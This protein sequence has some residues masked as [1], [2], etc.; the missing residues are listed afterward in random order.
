MAAKRRHCLK[1]P[2]GAGGG[3]ADD[4][5]FRGFRRFNLWNQRNLRQSA[6]GVDISG[7]G[8][9]IAGR[10]GCNMT[11]LEKLEELVYVGFE[12][13]DTMPSSQR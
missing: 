2:G 8:V 9:Y 3:I 11:T 6:V 13:T 5:R 7:W 4:H 1:Q 10:R 12:E